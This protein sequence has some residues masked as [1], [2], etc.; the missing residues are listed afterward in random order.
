MMLFDEPVLKE[1]LL[2]KT[3]YRLTAT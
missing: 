2:I 3:Y 1:L